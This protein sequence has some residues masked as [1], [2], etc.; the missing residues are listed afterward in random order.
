V[1]YTTN[2]IESL[3]SVIRKA[4]KNHKVFP[5]DQAAAKVV[6]LAIQHASKKWNMPIRDWKPAL[7]RFI[8]EFGDRVEHHL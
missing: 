4:M 1:I 7:N 6:F 5:T 3:N 8:L 2:A